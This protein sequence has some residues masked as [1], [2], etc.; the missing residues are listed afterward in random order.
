MNLPDCSVLLALT[1]LFWTTS[2]DEGGEEDDTNKQL[3]AHGSLMLIGWGFLLPLGVI[4]ARFFRHRADSVWFKL[5]KMQILGLVVAAIG[6]VIALNT[7][8]VLGSGIGS[9][10]IEDRK[11]MAHAICGSTA[12]C[13]GFVQP[14]NAIVRPHPPKDGEA[15]GKFRLLWEIVHKFLGYSAIILALVTIGLGV[16]LEDAAE[17]ETEFLAGYIAAL[18]ILAVI[19]FMMILDKMKHARDEKVL[20]VEKPQEAVVRS[21]E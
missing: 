15:K 20:S 4:S 12:M 21:D 9:A 19:T 16:F 1:L 2:A 7:W 6:W 18:A 8:D 17:Y 10:R 11:V 13:I 14:L 5:H 3:I